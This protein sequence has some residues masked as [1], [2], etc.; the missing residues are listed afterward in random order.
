LLVHLGNFFLNT[1]P[2]E[3]FPSTN[4]VIDSLIK[5][6]E[7][8]KELKLFLGLLKFGVLLVGKSEEGLTSIVRIKSSLSDVVLFLEL[9]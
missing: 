3:L 7:L 9:S 6:I 8:R 4:G 2:R 1:V 5:G